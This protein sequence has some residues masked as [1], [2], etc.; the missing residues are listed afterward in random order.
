M[1]TARELLENYAREDIVGFNDA[2]GPPR[3]RSAKAFAA[4]RA[5]LDQHP[6]RKFTTWSACDGCTDVDHLITWPCPTVEAI[7]TALEA[8]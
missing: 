5:V 2:E 8:K 6:E 7:M 3:G 1:T 4:L